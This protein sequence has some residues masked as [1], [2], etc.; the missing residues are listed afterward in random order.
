[1]LGLFWKTAP[2]CEAPFQKEAS[3]SHVKQSTHRCNGN[4][5]Q[6]TATLC[7]TLQHPATPC[8]TLQHTATHCNTIK[9]TATH[10]NTLQQT[11]SHGSTWQHAAAYC[12]TL[13]HTAA[14]CSTLQHTVSNCNTRFAPSVCWVSF[15][16]QDQFC[17]APFQIEASLPHVRQSTYCCNCNKLQH[18][19]QSS[20]RCNPIRNE[21]YRPLSCM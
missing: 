6:H 14:H 13:Q 4:T 19:M 9:H 10:C 16:K 20:H 18:T 17:W 12:S 2:F 5:L 21:I 1:M 7:N 8:N 3:L 15:G 11:A